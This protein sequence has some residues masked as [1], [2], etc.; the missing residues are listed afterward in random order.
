MKTV[1]FPY[2]RAW[3]WRKAREAEW[4]RVSEK[5]EKKN[6]IHPHKDRNAMS[7][8]K[9]LFNTLFIFLREILPQYRRII[10]NQ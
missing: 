2:T 5:G 3:R 7:N 4:E 1:L 8:T 10:D 9:Y 6:Q